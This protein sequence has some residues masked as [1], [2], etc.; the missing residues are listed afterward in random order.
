[1]TNRFLA[2]LG[3]AIG[4]MAAF[5]CPPVAARIAFEIRQIKAKDAGWNGGLLPLPHSDD[6]PPTQHLKSQ[7]GPRP[8]HYDQATPATGKIRQ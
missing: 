1:M 8:C 4:S 2:K 6:L 7:L 5:F 3:A